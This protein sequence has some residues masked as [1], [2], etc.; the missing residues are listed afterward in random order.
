[1]SHRVGYTATSICAPRT[2]RREFG[3]NQTKLHYL[4]VEV[5]DPPSRGAVDGPGALFDASA[6]V[7]SDEPVPPLPSPDVPLGVPLPDPVVPVVSPVLV[8][9]SVFVSELPFPVAEPERVVSASLRFAFGDV[10]VFVLSVRSVRLALLSQPTSA[11]SKALAVRT[12]MEA[13][14]R[15]F[16]QVVLRSVKPSVTVG[17]RLRGFRARE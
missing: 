2:G 12:Q 4:V 7:P 1:M 9:C 10:P 6:F 5:P 3:L 8:P 16:L 14:I 11:T 17:P 15:E 13:F